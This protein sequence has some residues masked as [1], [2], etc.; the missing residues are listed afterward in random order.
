M[1]A[2]EAEIEAEEEAEA[3]PKRRRGRPRVYGVYRI[4]T[5]ILVPYECYLKL[6]SYAALINRP[7]STVVSGLIQEFVDNLGNQDAEKTTLTMEL[8]R[9]CE[10]RMNLIEKLT[11]DELRNVNILM[12]Y[13]QT[14]DLRKAFAMSLF[15][16]NK[17]Q[18]KWT[19]QYN[20]HNL[21]AEVDGE[22]GEDQLTAWFGYATL[23]RDLKKRRDSIIAKL[24]GEEGVEKTGEISIIS[25][26][27]GQVQKGEKEEKL[28]RDENSPGQGAGADRW[29]P[30]PGTVA[31]D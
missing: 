17:G 20:G 30:P 13:Y 25:G 11:G 27:H 12:R 10:K 2:A 26:A 14:N 22:L 19:I 24:F 4:K 31:D 6:K 3:K 23:L 7:Y 18:R 8:T 21:V 5:H 28:W 1:A 9:I 16:Y 29:Q 15:D